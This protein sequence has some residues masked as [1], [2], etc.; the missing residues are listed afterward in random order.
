MNMI[1]I[2]TQIAQEEGVDPK[3][4]H[5]LYH[6]EA[7]RERGLATTWGDGGKAYGPMQLHAAA[8]D[9]VGV[10]RFNVRDN[11]RGGIRYY[12][13]QLDAYKNP[14]T[15]AVAYNRGPGM[16]ANILAGKAPEDQTSKG[17]DY[18]TKFRKGLERL[19][20][21]SPA[22]ADE[23][24]PTGGPQPKQAPAQD[25]GPSVER[26][27]QMLDAADAA[28][29]EAD[30]REIAAAIRQRRGVAMPPPVSPN[31]PHDGEGQPSADR[32]GQIPMTKP[33]PVA[34][35]PPSWT[36]AIPLTLPF[37][38]EAKAAGAATGDWLGQKLG[39]PN[40]AT[41]D[42]SANYTKALEAER[43]KQA[44]MTTGQQVVG[45]L[46]TG[47][48]MAE[49]RAMQGLSR[50]GRVGRSILTGAGVGGVYG[51]AGGE[52]GA[53]PDEGL[54]GWA[55]DA[56]NRG[57]AAVGPAVIGAGIGAAAPL[58][59]AVASTVGSSVP[60]ASRRLESLFR[61][62]GQ[63]ANDVSAA[64]AADPM[65]T[66]AEAIGE[67][68]RRMARAVA[69]MPGES[70]AI[71]EDLLRRRSRDA[72][73]RIIQRARETLGDGDWRATFDDLTRVQREEAAPL[74]NA[75]RQQPIEVTPELRDLMDRPAMRTAMTRARQT[76]ENHG[77]DSR[78]WFDTGMSPTA[79]QWHFARQEL[80][81]MIN[82]YRNQVTGRLELDSRGDSIV[83]VRDA[84]NRE[85]APHFADADA[86][87]SGVA[88]AQEALLS[89]ANFL[90]GTPDDIAQA[91]RRLPDGEMQF[92]RLGARQALEN[93][94]GG[95]TRGNDA[96]RGLADV[97]NVERKIQAV[98]PGQNS[99]DFIRTLG[100]EREMQA[101]GNYVMS[102]SRT[103]PMQ[104][105]IADLAGGAPDLSPVL[106]AIN[107]AR[108]SPS[109]LTRIGSR[110]W[111]FVT[112][113][114]N[115]RVRN[116]LGHLL[117]SQNPDDVLAAARALEQQRAAQRAFATSGSRMITGFG[118]PVTGSLMSGR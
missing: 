49:G 80:D 38:D 59:G 27:Y 61:R 3:L 88:R 2:I 82:R 92:Y 84:L 73:D 70:G 31:D 77:I 43:A 12:K 111:D 29:N 62:S 116:D 56:L 32:M 74:Y 9:E 10:D 6:N 11:I 23:V 54:M 45:G 58:V 98:F 83:R 39:L 36:E 106:D 93:K 37:A 63:N 52:G 89:G 24:S 1:P 67:P 16:A 35:E 79:D 30:A 13:K 105:D 118:A 86:V 101:F 69:G 90:K 112:R 66:T 114:G 19:A 42:W 34:P 14:L 94:I 102:G 17:L 115:E 95:V 103:A 72:G 46:A 41:G 22:A 64:M 15:A 99:A 85:M 110:A 104:Q 87:W 78:N 5:A 50:A 113:P 107:A 48:L 4:A 40:A 51:V 109:A 53:M 71:A 100:R 25:Q 91:I 65:L 26:L 97:P 96:T 108:G 7:D 8:A 57:E 76:A 60:K 47:P 33:E 117:Y 75:A 28:G 20:G 81:G 55:T 44:A 21:I 18:A 68:G